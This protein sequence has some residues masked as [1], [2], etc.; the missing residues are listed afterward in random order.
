MMVYCRVGWQ[1]PAQTRS[2]V[3]V[4]GVYSCCVIPN[5]AS[6]MQTWTAMHERSEVVVGLMYWY[7]SAVHTV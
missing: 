4:G 3:A 5:A 7:S 1:V 2:D 6:L